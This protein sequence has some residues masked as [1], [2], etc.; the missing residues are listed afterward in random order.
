M[1]SRDTGR[2]SAPP[3]STP[4][5]VGAFLAVAASFVLST[6]FTHRMTQQIDLASDAITENSAPSIQHLAAVRV[7]VRQLEWL[8]ADYVG[9]FP[10]RAPDRAAVDS[11][12]AAIHVEVRRYLALPL[13]PGERPR[14]D[15]IHA[16]V[17]ELTGE[18]HR[19]M[20]LAESG[21]RDAARSEYL[22]LL[23]PIAARL[24]SAAMDDIEFNAQNGAAMASRIKQ[25]R[26]QAFVVGI[27]VDLMCV[28]LAILASLIVAHQVRRHAH[29]LTT[30]AR[31][32][33]NRAGEL[34][35]FADRVAHDVKSPIGSA[36]LRMELVLR[37]ASTDARTRHL[38]DDAMRSLRRA[39]HIVDGLFQFARAGASPDPTAST[40]VA[41]VVEEVVAS[42]AGDAERAGVELR[43][44]LGACAVGCTAGVLASVVSNLVENAIKYGT[45]APPCRIDVRASMR[46]DCVRIEVDDHGPGI[47]P[48]VVGRVFEPYV[49]A[50]SRDDKP[51]LG[52]GLATVKRL[53]EGHQGR[54]GVDTAPGRGSIFWFELPAARPPAALQRASS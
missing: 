8:L 47:P 21:Q 29:L 32:L 10:E 48:D 17:V 36:Q 30:H 31:L 3:P 35:S 16:S 40:D 42:L 13:F 51:G 26:Q 7:E 15:R 6:L 49:R 52:L 23:R 46:A 43:C 45:G 11:S 27:A 22:T 25:V 4:L 5:L 44:E 41:Q 50:P 53:V 1:R 38:V 37:Q 39:A 14:W 19:V 34:E 24:I 18:A 9:I 12:L 54:V 33:E 28:A 20:A 2:P